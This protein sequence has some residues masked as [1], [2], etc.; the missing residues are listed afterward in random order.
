MSR[1]HS[2][3]CNLYNNICLL[4]FSNY[5]DFDIY[6]TNYIKRTQIDVSRENKIKIVLSYKVKASSIKSDKLIDS[7][8]FIWN[9]KN[10]NWGIN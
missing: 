8:F 4:K 9:F 2:K 7:F 10:F 6:Y 1:P 5:Q 3:Y